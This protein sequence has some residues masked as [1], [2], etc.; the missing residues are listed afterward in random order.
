MLKV[1]VIKPGIFTSVQDGGRNGYAFYGIPVSGFMD[2]ESAEIAN[3]LVGNKKT[4]TLIEM[5]HIGGTFTFSEDC[6][7][8]IT[9]ANMQPV[10][11]L[12]TCKMYQTLLV[13]KGATLQF[14]NALSGVRTY[15]AIKGKW[16]IPRVYGSTA[17]YTYAGMG[18]FR[19]RTLQAKDIINIKNKMEVKKTPTVVWPDLIN[20]L[21]ISE[22]EIAK[23]PEFSF[24][25]NGEQLFSSFKISPSSDRMGAILEGPIIDIQ[26]QDSFRSKFLFPGMIQ[27][28]P[29]GKLIVVLQ[30]GQSTGGYPRVGVI[31]KHELNR[32]N[33]LQPSQSFELIKKT[34]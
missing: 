6:V 30:D 2:R 32:F 21:M 13:K 5:H 17:T 11:N 16:D 26:L 25:K 19:G 22:I 3:I 24:L 29:S 31:P 12:V 33:Q 1:K 15:L 20:Y 34:S 28:T 27:C 18:G 7:I 9:G 10:L 23:G 8:A 4:A 14:K